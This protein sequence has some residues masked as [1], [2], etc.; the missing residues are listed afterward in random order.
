MSA[1][2]VGLGRERLRWLRCDR[3]WLAFAALRAAA[4]LYA[5]ALATEAVHFVARSLLDIAPWLV[6]AVLLGAWAQASGSDALVARAFAGRTAVAVPVAA[7]VGAVSPFCS[8]GV[9]PLIAGLLG[10]GVPLAPIMAFWL[11]SPIVDP[12]TFVLT[13][14][15]LG[16]PYALGK[17]LSAF[18]L[19]LLG[20]FGTGLLTRSTSGGSP[21]RTGMVASRTCCSPCGGSAATVMPAIWRDRARLRR[22]GHESL[23]VGRLLLKWLA[24][25]FLLQSLMLE[26]VPAGLVARAVGGEGWMPVLIATL[27]G[28]PA[29]L[30]GYAALPVVAGL[31]EQGM[32]PGAAMAFLVAGGVSCVP[33]AVAVWA[34]VRLPVFLAY[35]AFAFAGSMLAGL[36]FGLLHPL[37]PAAL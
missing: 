1:V 16:F 10:A 20:G 25:A 19:E 6:F 12:S 37:L 8:C 9:I 18:L 32:M 23:R 4:A 34:V 33:A 2:V 35:L 28:V 14:S 26:L 15:I 13:V 24:L 5:P 30:N 17:T 31:L 21:L 3:V 27:V 11:S 29:Y 22:F 36:G 7:L